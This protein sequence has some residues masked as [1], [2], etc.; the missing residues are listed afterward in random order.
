MWSLDRNMAADIP[1]ER[2]SASAC[3][4]LSFVQKPGLPA[5]AQEACSRFA[6]PGSFVACHLF[7]ASVQPLWAPEGEN[8]RLCTH[9]GAALGRASDMINVGSVLAGVQ[10]IRYRSSLRAYSV[11]PIH[12]A[13]NSGL[14]GGWAAA[15][16]RRGCWPCASPI[17]IMISPPTCLTRSDDVH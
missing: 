16:G 14:I 4:V 5:G 12:P 3:A 15:A 10:P 11:F 17:R 13:V 7:V 9:F 6:V 8:S 2:A 1:M